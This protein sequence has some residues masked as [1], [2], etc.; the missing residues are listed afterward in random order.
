MRVIDYV[1][2]ADPS[3]VAALYKA[4]YTDDG[5]DSVDAFNCFKSEINQ[6]IVVQT[7]MT[8]VI[9]EDEDGG[10]GVCGRNGEADNWAIEY[11]P[12]SEWKWMEVYAPT[13][14]SVDEIA[15]NIYYEITWG[16]WEESGQQRLDEIMDSLESVKRLLGES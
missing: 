11:R 15:T 2:Q 12:W 16:G 1:N 10:F 9:R 13:G 7:D 14:M 6:R 3:A 4:A 5:W 8:V